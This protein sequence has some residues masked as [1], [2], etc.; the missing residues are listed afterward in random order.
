MNGRLAIAL[1]I[2]VSLVLF[3]I[4]FSGLSD[5]GTKNGVDLSAKVGFDVGDDLEAP[6]VAQPSDMDHVLRRRH[7]LYRRPHR[8]RANHAQLC[9]S[10]WRAW[11]LYPPSEQR[12]A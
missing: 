7:S 8:S 2:G 5:P 9:D 11:Y 12:G 4:A 10:G 3:G 6:W 1:G